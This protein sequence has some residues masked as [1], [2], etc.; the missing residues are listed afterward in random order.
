MINDAD[1]VQDMPSLPIAQTTTA[2]EECDATKLNHWMNA[3]NI[4]FS[5]I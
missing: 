5:L 2:V 4:K 1:A 3:G